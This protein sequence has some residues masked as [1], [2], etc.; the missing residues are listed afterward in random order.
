MKL[1]NSI[2]NKFVLSSKFS[3]DGPL[4]MKEEY[5]EGIFETLKVDEDIVSEQ[6]KCALDHVVKTFQQLLVPLRDIVSRCL[7][8]PLV[9]S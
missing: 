5:S 2:E 6:L 1:L 9:K 8:I 7:K 4:R 3:V